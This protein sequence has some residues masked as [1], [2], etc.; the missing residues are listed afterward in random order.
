MVSGTQWPGGDPFLQRQNEPSLDVS[1]RNPL[2]LVAGANDYRTVDL[3]FDDA[4][5]PEGNA[6]DAWLGVF[7][8]FDGGRTW[9]STLLPGYPRTVRPRPRVPLK[10]LAAAA[11]PTVRAGASGVFLYSGIA[12]NRGN[13]APGVLFVARFIDNNDKEYGDPAW[14]ATRSNTSAPS[15]SIPG[16]RAS[17]STSRRW[18]STSRGRET[19]PARSRPRRTAAAG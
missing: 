2:H 11:D 9:R 7:K 15:S 18:P 6:G 19:R 3:P 17:S 4:L 5:P 12:F 14:A 13:N 1:T 8:S 10:G 16:T